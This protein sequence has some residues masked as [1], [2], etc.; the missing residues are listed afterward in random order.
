[1]AAGLTRAEIEDQF[2]A[3]AD[4]ADIGEA[5]DSPMKTYSAG[6]YSRLAFAVAVVV[7]PD[8]LIVDE[9]LSTGDAKF[10]KKSLEKI[11]TLRGEN[12]AI[13]LVSHALAT[14][15][16]IC[17]D[18]IWLDKGKI[19]MRGNP[20]EVVAAYKESLQVAKSSS[21]DEDL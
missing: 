8:V 16:E 1:L 7:E 10:K 9:A 5:I 17:N 14:I 4:F 18:V 6:M 21:A 2:S 19:V 15:K 12:R 3:I 11:K 20:D 13:I